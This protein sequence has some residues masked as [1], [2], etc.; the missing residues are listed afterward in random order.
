MP[1]V[2][3]Q[4]AAEVEGRCSSRALAALAQDVTCRPLWM[5]SMAS[6]GVV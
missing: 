4:E 2:S 6:C 1:T 3:L 5:A